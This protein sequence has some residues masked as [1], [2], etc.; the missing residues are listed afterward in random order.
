MLNRQTVGGG[1]ACRGL[2]LFILGAA[3]LFGAAV[4]QGENVAAFRDKLFDVQF[5]GEAEA[6]AVGYPGMILHTADAGATWTHVDAGTDEALF[7]VSFP[8][9]QNGWISG[10]RGTILHTADGGK[11]WSVQET[12]TLEPLFSIDFVDARHGCAVGNFGQILWTDDGGG[13]WVLWELQMQIP[14]PTGEDGEPIEPPFDYEP[15]ALFNASLNAVAVLDAKTAVVAGEYPAWELDY[16]AYL[17]LDAVSNMY[18]T[19]DGGKTWTLIK[20]GST[21]FIYDMAFDTAGKRGYAVGTQGELLVTDDGGLTWANIPTGQANH[22]VGVA[23][24]ASGCWI[25]GLDGVILTVTGQ[26]VQAS[27]SDVYIWLCSVA[28]NGAGKGIA[29]GGRGSLLITADG[30]KSW[31]SID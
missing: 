18:R 10:R 21:K 20:N 23:V 7:S 2:S 14:A 30:A 9:P 31:K 24:T 3:L 6:W 16:N 4:A 1:R 13:T 19:D 5:V 28:T 15:E 25:A 27:P 22:L 26:T 29:V 17:T 12:A 11:T 8:D